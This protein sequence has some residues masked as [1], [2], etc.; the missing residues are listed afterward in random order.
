MEDLNRVALQY[1]VDFVVWAGD[2]AYADGLEDRLHRW[3]WWFDSNMNSLI[4]WDGRVVPVIVGIGNHETLH[5]RFYEADDDFPDYRGCIPVDKRGSYFFL[6]LCLMI[7]L[8][9]DR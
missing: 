8:M 7:C 2:F 4:D 9:L 3:Y 5:G 1:D 6:P